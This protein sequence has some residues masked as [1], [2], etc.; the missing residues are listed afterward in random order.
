MRALNETEI[1]RVSGGTGTMTMP[2][3]IVTAKVRSWA[4]EAAMY[5]G[6]HAEVILAQSVVQGS[7]V[8]ISPDVDVQLT[9]PQVTV[10]PE[11]NPVWSMDG[12]IF[13]DIYTDSRNTT[14]YTDV[15][16]NRTWFDF[17]SDGSIDA[18]WLGSENGGG[19][20]LVPG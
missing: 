2:P 5:G 18:L 10:V 1:M 9:M 6:A 15:E 17:N 11:T 7:V 20:F 19:A 14:A 16:T 3:V 13:E 12:V 4:S 8:E